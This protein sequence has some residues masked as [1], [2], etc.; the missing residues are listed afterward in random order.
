MFLITK[1]SFLALA[2]SPGFAGAASHST[3]RRRH[4]GINSLDYGNVTR[5][6]ENTGVRLTMYTPQTGSQVSCGGFYHDSDY[7]RFSNLVISALG[8]L[9]LHVPLDRRTELWCTSFYAPVD[10]R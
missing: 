9:T 5:R 8:V 2:L 10:Y 4:A 6:D 1:L 3:P 7:V